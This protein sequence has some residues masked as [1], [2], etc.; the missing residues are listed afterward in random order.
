MTLSNNQAPGDEYLQGPSGLTA[1]R[2]LYGN[3]WSF[4]F[5]IALP[6]IGYQVLTLEHVKSVV[7]LSLVSIFPL[8]A[9]LVGWVRTRRVDILGAL[10]F[11]FIVV[12]VATGLI[13][14]SPRFLLLKESAFT[15]IFGLVFLGSLL[16]E[17]PVMFYF[18]RQFA[19]GGDPDRVAAWDGLWQYPQFR[20]AQRVITAVWGIGWLA[21]ALVRVGLVFVLSVTLFMGSHRSYSSESLSVCSCG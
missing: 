11:V 18:G 16:R 12:G 7:A 15:G 21:D 17:R 6:F 8:G 1:L 13:T 4:L 5:T 2:A 20:H 19:T 9:T 3:G 14:G 10:S